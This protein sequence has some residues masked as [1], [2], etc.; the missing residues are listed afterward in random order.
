VTIAAV[1]AT[2]R[3]EA[4]F[5][6]DA[7]WDEFHQVWDDLQAHTR[8]T[9]AGGIEAAADWIVANR[10]Q[11]DLIVIA[12]TRPG[13]IHARQVH[14]LRRLAPLA[15]CVAVLG[16]WCE[17]EARTGNPWPGMPR[18]YWHQWPIAA[19]R[20]LRRLADERESWWQLPHTA[21]ADERFLVMRGDECEPQHGLVAIC[22]RD[23]ESTE[24]LADLCAAAGYQ[25]VWYRRD[26]PPRTQGTC[27]VVWDGDAL[28][29]FAEEELCRT[30]RVFERVPFI[31]LLNYPRTTDVRH[32]LDCGATCALSKPIC[33]EDLLAALGRPVREPAELLP[34]A[35][36]R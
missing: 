19:L 27:A 7:R 8:L 24:A 6:G 26:K 35:L 29:R 31:V 32:A 28:D 12:Q 2:Q 21:A 15:R 16:S 11:P 9:H 23:W 17:G 5:V 33:V 1:E 20:E 34:S 14:S 30:R 3:L 22:A 10:A 13:Q 18:L 36:G 4:L 25:S